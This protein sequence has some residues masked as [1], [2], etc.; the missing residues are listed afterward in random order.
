MH[1]MLQ[2]H[3]DCILNRG[4]AENSRIT[5]IIPTVFCFNFNR[6]FA[7][8]WRNSA[9]ALPFCLYSHGS[10]LCHRDNFTAK[11]Q[12]VTLSNHHMLVIS[13]FVPLPL[14]CHVWVHPLPTSYQEGLH[15][16]LGLP[17]CLWWHTARAHSNTQNTWEVLPSTQCWTQIF[18]IHWFQEFINSEQIICELFFWYT[19][20]TASSIMAEVYR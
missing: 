6:L 10:V 1:K 8:Y 2:L 9:A 16:M 14:C 20:I 3:T 11:F 15:I 13:L 18:I 17:D 4:C 12:N 19:L 7:S 5:A